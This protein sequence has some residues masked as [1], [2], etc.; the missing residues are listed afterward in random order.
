[1][2]PPWLTATKPIQARV[3][4]KAR[5]SCRWRR[6]GARHEGDI[7]PVNEHGGEVLAPPAIPH[8]KPAQEGFS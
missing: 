1:M 5:Q 3:H 6:T 8:E 7:E 4:A 2:C